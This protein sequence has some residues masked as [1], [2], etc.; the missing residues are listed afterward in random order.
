M[1]NILTDPPLAADPPFKLNVPAKTLG[2]VLRSS[3]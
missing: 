1:A 3:V 2:L